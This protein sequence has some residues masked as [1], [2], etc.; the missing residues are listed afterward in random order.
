V[1]VNRYQTS[2]P[3]RVELLRIDAE[4]EQ[5]QAASVARL[6]QARDGLAW[7]SSM[8]SLEQV[9]RGAGNLVPA[10][11]AAVEAHATLGEVSDAFRRVFGEHRDNLA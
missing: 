5:R 3:A 2:E 6:R 4:S 1:G 10:V 11:L 9:A 8:N 7:Q